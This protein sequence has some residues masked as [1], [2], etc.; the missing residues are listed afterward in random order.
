MF[1]DKMIKMV[2]IKKHYSL[3]NRD[4]HVLNGISLEIARG[5]FISLMGPSGSGKTTLMN[6]LGCLDRPDSGDIFLEGQSLLT[7]DS[8]NLA[9]I[10][11]TRIGIIFQSFNLIPVL[12]AYENVEF[13]LLLQS[14]FNKQA[15]TRLVMQVLEKVG[16]KDKTD[17]KPDELSGGQMQRVAVARAIVTQPQIIIADEPTGNLDSVTGKAII[18]L[19]LKVNKDHENTVIIS[20]HDPEVMQRAKRIVEIQ[21]GMIVND[22]YK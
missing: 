21:D 3:N 18:D 9:R 11:A 19:L 16:L 8:K 6:M 4:V 10:R 22:K 5:E 13:P 15:R 2:D 17:H 12:T 20:T 7:L 1:N 14:R